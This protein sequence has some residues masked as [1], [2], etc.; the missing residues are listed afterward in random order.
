MLQCIEGGGHGGGH[1]GGG[2]D[3]GNGGGGGGSGGGDSGNGGGGGV[4][5]IALLPWFCWPAAPENGE[6]NEY[7]PGLACTPGN[8]MG[9]L[10]QPPLPGKDDIRIT[11]KPFSSRLPS[12]PSPGHLTL[13][14]SPHTDE[15]EVVQKK[16]F[17]KW[18]NS[19]L[20]RVSCRISDLYKDLRDGR[21]LIKLLEVLS[22]EMLVRPSSVPAPQP[23]A[24]AINAS[25]GKAFAGAQ[26]VPLAHRV[27]PCSLRGPG[28]H[29][30]KCWSG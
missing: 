3:D 2:G 7:M 24:D 16:T 17:T 13:G 10:Q 19:H 26:R 23:V 20:A 28:S 9:W 21:M 27:F 22:G 18:V 29:D 25:S 5:V 30:V 4:V 8:K 1:G 11:V 6:A 14:S 15:R 12:P